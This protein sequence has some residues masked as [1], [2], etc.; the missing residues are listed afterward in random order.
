MG[1]IPVAHAVTNCPG[2]AVTRVVFVGGRVSASMKFVIAPGPAPVL[3]S[4]KMPTLLFT[5]VTGAGALVWPLQVTV[6]WTGPRG[7][8]DG[9]MALIWRSRTN[10]G[11]ALT[12]VPPPVTAIETPAKVVSRGNRGGG[13]VPTTGPRLAPKI[14]KIEPCAME[15][16]GSD[17]GIKVA[18]FTIPFST[19]TGWANSAVGAIKSKTGR[20]ADIAK[21]VL[22]RQLLKRGRQVMVSFLGR[23]AG[24]S[25]LEAP[26]PSLAW[27]LPVGGHSARSN[28]G[29]RTQNKTA[30]ATGVAPS[31]RS[32][33]WTREPTVAGC[34]GD[35]A[36]TTLARVLRGMTDR[37]A[38]STAPAH[39]AR[40]RT[41]RTSHGPLTATSKI[42]CPCLSLIGR[43]EWIP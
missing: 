2:R 27:G 11:I 40:L 28:R 16:P 23:E 25:S 12:V 6:T 33:E 34:R 30:S 26:I 31:N 39:R 43:A 35:Q 5:T 15:P 9:M 8:F 4:V 32:R 18:A 42:V 21:N 1:P 13:S 20:A 29:P 17:G 10:T 24:V 41:L 37:R 3:K 38:R 36:S 7:A 22:Q 14:E 19:I